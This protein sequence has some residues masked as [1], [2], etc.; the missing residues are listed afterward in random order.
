MP[1]EPRTE[2]TTRTPASLSEP[3]RS[4]SPERSGLPVV[5][6]LSVLLLIAMGSAGYFY[7]QYQFGGKKAD[8]EEIAK[9]TAEIGS[10]FLLPEGET[11]TLATVTD[12]EKLAEQPFFQNAENGDKVLIYTNN[13]RAILYRPSTKKIVDV[14]TVNV[15][16][17]KQEEPAVPAGSG[18][19][20]VPQPVPKAETSRT[21]RVVLYNGTEK[22]GITNSFED[23]LM[24][25]VEGVTVAGKE[26]AKRNDYAKTKVIDLTRDNAALVATIA[27]EYSADITDLPDGE[28][29]PDADILIILGADRK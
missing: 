20:D 5:L 10:A 29:R 11:P 7:Y 26:V 27:R 2:K 1:R 15:N 9:L 18:A 4:G 23:V 28:L 21:V 22:L 3:A 6:V 16:V 14:T 24:K 25:N 17:P 13:G 12:K 8:A 19:V